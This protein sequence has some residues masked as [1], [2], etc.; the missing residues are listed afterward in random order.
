MATNSNGDV[1][2]P[3]I[4]ILPDEK[5]IDDFLTLKQGMK[6]ALLI[7]DDAGSRCARLG[8]IDKC[9]LRGVSCGFLVPHNFFV[10]LT[11]T[12][13]NTAYAD[14]TA[15]CEDSEVDKL[16]ATINHRIL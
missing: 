12:M 6:V 4:P 15:Y 13:V 7:C 16:S 3:P 8:I 10:I 14:Q 11:V 1:G 2:G 5:P 9:S